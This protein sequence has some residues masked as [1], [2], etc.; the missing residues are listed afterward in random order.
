MIQ[1]IIFFATLALR[2]WSRFCTSSAIFQTSFDT[3]NTVQ[4][5]QV[6]FMLFF[7]FTLTI[8]VRQAAV[9]AHRARAEIVTKSLKIFLTQTFPLCGAT[10]YIVRL[11]LMARLFNGV[12]F[13]YRSVEVYRTFHS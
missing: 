1:H 10:C 5:L 3:S 9:A 11:R 6:A 4:L 8:S 12:N 7:N 13:V 2:R